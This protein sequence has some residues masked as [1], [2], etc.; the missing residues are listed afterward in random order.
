MVPENIHDELRTSENNNFKS[1]I[2][3]SLLGIGILQDDVYDYLN[4]K[5]AEIF[6]YKVEE[7][8]GKN[9][10]EFIKLVYPEDRAFVI[11]QARKKQ[12]RESDYILNYTFRGIK[13]SGEIIWVETF[14][15]PIT[16]RDRPADL[17][18]L[19]D[20]TE[21]KRKEMELK[22]SKEKY[23][24]ITE[25]ANDL[26][27]I[28]NYHN[29]KIEYINENVHKK[30]LGYDKKDLI[31]KNPGQ[32]VHPDDLRKAMDIAKKYW[33]IGESIITLR[34]RKK[35]GDYVWLEVRGKKFMDIDGVE[36]IL[37]FSRNVTEQIKTEQDLIES[38]AKYKTILEQSLFGICIFH[39]KIIYVNQKFAEIV[40]YSVE[41]ILNMS[42]DDYPKVVHPED[43]SSI[44]ASIRK[45]LREDNDVI[46]NYPVRGI[47]KTGE[48]IWVEIYSKRIYYDGKKATL[49]MIVDITEK[50]E[51]ERKYMETLNTLPDI[52]FETDKNLI[53]T[54]TNKSGLETF[55]YT[56]EEI[57]KGL[58]VTNMVAPNELDV[59]IENSKKVMEGKIRTAVDAKF[60]KKDG[61]EFWGRINARPI[62]KE[63]VVIGMRGV[64]SDITQRKMMEEKLK[65][66]E[67][68]YRF[69]AE[70]MD[71]V[72]AVFG[73]NFKLIY[74]NEAQERLSGFSRDEVL[75]TQP[76]D[77][78]H[79]DDVEIVTNLMKDAIKTG[80]T[81]GE[82][83]LK[84]K[85]GSYKW[86]E[87]KAKLITDK[88]GDKKTI[89]VMRDAD[90]RK[91]LEFKLKESE[92][93]YRETLDLLPDIIYEADLEQNIIY[94]NN[95]ALKKFGYSRDD[96]EKGLP[97]SRVMAPKELERSTRAIKRILSGEI[98]EPA[99][100]L[101]VT[102]N[103]DEFWG[104]IHNRPIY[105]E[106]KIIG[107]RGVIV[108]VSERKKMEKELR[109]SKQQLSGIVNSITDYMSVIDEKYNIL[110]ANE[111]A[112]EKFGSE[113]V[114][115]TCYES[116]HRTNKPCIECIVAK[117]FADGGIHEH[118]T[119]VLDKEGTPL[120]L[121][122]TAN[123][124][125][126]SRDGKPKSI[127]KISRDITDRKWF[128]ER[129]I[130]SEEKFRRIFHSIPDLFFII[131]EDTTIIDYSGKEKDFFIPP[132]QF[133]GKRLI[134]IMP[135]S[136]AN[137]ILG[138]VK[139]TLNTKEPQTLEYK[140]DMPQGLSYY[141]SRIL[142]YS[143]NK[144]A[145]FIRDI[146]KRKIAEQKLIESEEKYRLISENANDLIS[147]LNDKFVFEYINS[148]VHNKI[149]GYR[150][151]ELIG[152]AL[153]EF[154]HPENVR[155]LLD[156]SRRTWKKGEI[157]TVVRFVK[158]D[159]S[160]IWL[161][162]KGK[163]FIDKNSKQKLLLVG[164]DI[165]GRKIA[166]Q[167]L[168]ESE[169]KLKE[170]VQQYRST[171]ES[172]G[173]ALHVINSDYN[174]IL[175]NQ[176]LKIWTKQL[177]LEVDFVG[178][179]IFEVFP[180][181]PKKTKE[182]YE[183]LFKTGRS[184]VTIEKIDFPGN[185]IYTETRKIPIYS[186]G[187]V[188]QIITIVRDITERK[189]AEERVSRKNALLNAINEVFQVSMTCESDVEVAQKYLSVASELFDCRLGF[190][191]EFEKINEFKIIS[192]FV[193]EMNNLKNST[194][195]KNRMPEFF[196]K[197]GI[198]E[199][200]VKEKRTLVVNE[201][202]VNSYSKDVPES[203]Y[204]IKNFI[205]TPLKIAENV[206][207]MICLANKET[208]IEVADARDLEAL[209]TAFM[210]ALMK[211]RAEQEVADHREHL[212]EM[213]HESIRELRISTEQLQ[214]KTIEHK[215]KD[216]ELRETEAKYRDTLDFLPDPIYEA[217]KDLNIIYA[218]Q[219]AFKKFGYTQEDFVKGLK[220]SQ[221]IAPSFLNQ[222]QYS[223]NRLLS[224]FNV[225]PE[226]YKFRTK[227]G[228]EFWG[229]A[230]SVPVF[231]EG[232][233]IGIR[234][235][236]VDVSDRKKMEDTLRE[237]EQRFRNFIENASDGMLVADT[238]RMKFAFGNRAICEMLGY[239]PEEIQNMGVL[240][241]HP[242]D[243]LPY[244]VEQFEK[245]A[246]REIILA[247]NIPVQRKDGSVFYADINSSKIYLGGKELLLGMF[248]DITERKDME[249]KLR[250]LSE[251][252]ERVV[253]K[254]TEELKKAQEK[255][256][257]QEK[258][259]AIGKFSKSIIRKLQNPIDVMNKI[260]FNLKNR[261]RDS[262]ENIRSELNKMQ[263]AVSRTN[264]LIRELPDFSTSKLP[265]LIE[266]DVN[267]IIE[268]SLSKINI[269]KNIS[270]KK[271]YYD[272]LEKIKADPS[273]LKIAF[274]NIIQNAIQAMHKGGELE[275]FSNQTD[276]LI[277][278][279]FKDTGA[280]I[281][282]ANLLRIFDPFFSTKAKNIG[283]GLVIV[284]DIVEKHSGKIEVDSKIG[285]GSIFTIIL[286]VIKKNNEI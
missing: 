172:L 138:L 50:K 178:M 107:M 20:I 231:R 148:I 256:I 66:S 95:A 86:V 46:F 45:K 104:R 284:K 129:L 283:L 282:D 62:Y 53:L 117:A 78:L 128:E 196:K 230:H 209:S 222:V 278:I 281:S 270:I 80:A 37:I 71:D 142:Y 217:D 238:E 41:E 194:K 57:E 156:S 236:V 18:M 177:G 59:A 33:N 174:I 199:K 79:P 152:K 202:V 85:D 262:D 165:S 188:A 260:I 189:L 54:Y 253:E 12:S 25:S 247:K 261:L 121:W 19:I 271:L 267:E 276:D 100:Y 72:I 126:K 99:D 125:T 207:G 88:E 110:W 16:Y 61:T 1:I 116:F 92:A 166:E 4:P 243:E 249:E 17:I 185:I 182:E 167:K 93:R 187:K 150:K 176:A 141:E 109:T 218:N 169:A 135:K 74:I 29:A 132:E 153:F 264:D 131:S 75:N 97:L 65:E 179:N 67:E 39:K 170:S 120:I 203:H 96:L 242:K 232:K 144:V 180:F 251:N 119:E 186:E 77:F 233:V 212:E 108:D 51:A 241:I 43:W 34:W 164:R 175:V 15:K 226:D 84:R 193:P 140:L 208:S 216:M 223:L 274:T 87:A 136:I 224:G 76:V 2:D 11:E 160:Y 151:D 279:S 277:E 273:Q 155:N 225:E 220:I 200:I 52:V 181:L 26:I 40:G 7:I 6:G 162:Y 239:T 254:K 237:S 134:D 83:R 32:F 157:L 28:I 81:Q 123:V 191:G 91:K 161:E 27:S 21:K 235:V 195:Q 204:K 257:M 275:I 240:D 24:L 105:K 245:Q 184:L 227:D 49:A 30:I 285:E 263:Q 35:N 210:E 111:T 139:K 171:I 9:S 173:D 248:R 168:R 82:F 90:K 215:K 55:G 143:E 158:K 197:K 198:L 269:P 265:I 183:Y 229:R 89:V 286:P 22:D 272:N 3:Q 10:S 63:G 159:G 68:K 280:G 268:E 146:T 23:R 42:P 94:A 114:G 70:N 113:I 8:L 205:A 47:K 255:L 145:I 259:E 122:S 98:T 69:M 5:F 102:K 214:K 56:Q 258:I 58:K 13:K 244:V 44:I 213:I 101:F 149:L 124:L 103:G 14:S 60:I 38:E 163:V 127:I 219:A 154:I 147:I 201:A 73:K 133:H 48:T 252:L 64:I 211:K 250:R 228:A 190:I 266:C 130:E 112:K 246:K 36:K 221:M 106:G 115:K 234:G 137:K 192:Y 206:F 31:G 118:E